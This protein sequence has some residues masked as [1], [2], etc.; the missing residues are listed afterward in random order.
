M[1][2][3]SL[4]RNHEHSLCQILGAEKTK[5]TSLLSTWPSFCPSNVCVTGWRL[6]NSWWRGTTLSLIVQ[7]KLRLRQVSVNRPQSHSDTG[8]VWESQ[9]AARLQPLR[10]TKPP[11]SLLTWEEGSTDSCVLIEVEKSSPS[12]FC[13]TGRKMRSYN[14]CRNGL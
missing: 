3:V 7:E 13:L 2:P 8:Q 14:T 6:P 4:L 10:L 9:L 11:L 1:D 5:L 12:Q